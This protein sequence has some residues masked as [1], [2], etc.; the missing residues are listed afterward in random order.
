MHRLRLRGRDHGYRI[1]F[2][3]SRDRG[4]GSP[5]LHRP[6]Y[7]KLLDKLPC[8]PPTLHTEFLYTVNP[9]LRTDN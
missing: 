9:G 8:V 5:N 6:H 3:H 1:S 2:L 4:V 7:K